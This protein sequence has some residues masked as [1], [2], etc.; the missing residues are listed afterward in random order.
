MLIKSFIDLIERV[1][2]IKIGIQNGAFDVVIKKAIKLVH[3]II[4]NTSGVSKTR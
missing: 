3:I 1:E 2:C 4:A